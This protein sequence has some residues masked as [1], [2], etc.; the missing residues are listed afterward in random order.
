MRDFEE[1]YRFSLFSSIPKFPEPLVFRITLK[2]LEFHELISLTLSK[3][4]EQ[5]QQFQ[6]LKS[7]LLHQ[8][9]LKSKIA[10]TEVSFKFIVSI[11]INVVLFTF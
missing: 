11:Y 8:E 10:V 5:Y 1:F 4:E 3:F 2:S 6:E 7:M 9:I